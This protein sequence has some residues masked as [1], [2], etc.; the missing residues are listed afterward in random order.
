MT[1]TSDL[2]LCE[3]LHV[4]LGPRTLSIIIG[5]LEIRIYSNFRFSIVHTVASANKLCIV[6]CAKT[7][8]PLPN[9]RL[10]ESHMR[11]IWRT[12]VVYI[13]LVEPLK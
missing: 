8:R 3:K 7:A 4:I 10:L 5:C 11:L 2:N 6:S 9:A 13:T 1:E 12:P